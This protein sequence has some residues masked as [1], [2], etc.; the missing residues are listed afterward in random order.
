MVAHTAFDRCDHETADEYFKLALD[1]ADKA[2]SWELRANTLAEVARK[3][4]CLNK[5]DTHLP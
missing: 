4:I 5:E 3:E 1:C 2:P